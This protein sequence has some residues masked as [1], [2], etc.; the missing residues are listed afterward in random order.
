M[1]NVKIENKKRKQFTEEIQFEQNSK[2]IKNLQDV[3]MVI[4]NEPE[5]NEPITSEIVKYLPL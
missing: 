2:K 5:P 3:R 4:L 1:E